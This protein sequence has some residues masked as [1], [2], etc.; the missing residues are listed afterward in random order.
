[1]RGVVILAKLYFRYGAMGSSKTLNCLAV[2]HNY[3]TYQNKPIFLIKPSKD[4]RKKDI[5]SRN[6][7]N[8]KADLILNPSDNDIVK[9]ILKSRKNIHCVLVD[10]AQFLTEMQVY[11]LSEVVDNLNIPVIC[12]GLKTNFQ[13]NFNGFDGAEA[14]LRWADKIEEIKTVCF[15]SKCNKKA[16]HNLRLQDGIPTFE[17]EEIIIGDLPRHDNQISFEYRPICR[18]CYKQEMFSYYGNSIK[19]EYIITSQTI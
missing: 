17:G 3:E 2:A 12:Y 1:L 15:N 7:W 16:T 18:A 11:E 8:R 6:G 5:T 14:L 13:N 10:E 19:K 9:Q 4:L